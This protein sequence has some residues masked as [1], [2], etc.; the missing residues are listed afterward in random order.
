MGTTAW[1]FVHVLS[2][3]FGSVPGFRSCNGVGEASPSSLLFFSEVL[4]VLCRGP[5]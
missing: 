1:D 4:V 3:V 5:S 2:Y